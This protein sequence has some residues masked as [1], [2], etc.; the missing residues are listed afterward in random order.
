MDKEE[1]IRIAR[2]IGTFETSILPY[3]DCCTVFTP[4]PPQAPAPPWRRSRRP[5][6]RWTST[7]WCRR[8]VENEHP[9]SGECMT[10]VKPCT[11]E[12]IAVG[13]ELLLGNIANTD[14]ADDLPERCPSWA[15]TSTTT[16][17]WGTTPTR[18]PQAVEHAR[19]TR[20][21]ILI[22][23][24]GLGPTCDDLTKQTVWPP[25]FG[26]K[27]V[28]HPEHERRAHPRTTSPPWAA[29]MT[30]NNLQQ[31]ML[32]EGCT[33]LD[34][35]WGTAPGCAFDAERRPRHHAP[36]PAPG[37][38][39]PCSSTGRCP[40]CQRLSD[41]DHRLPHRPASSAWASQPGGGHA[42]R[43]D[44][45]A[46]TNPTLAPYAKADE[47]DAA[48]HRQGAPREAEAEAMLAPRGAN[49]SRLS[50]AT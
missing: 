16:P 28:F 20:A 21:D 31:A 10:G 37:V 18:L 32:P 11:A 23:T 40:I 39:R 8:A 17:S 47:C 36:R 19:K 1:I 27:L 30:E 3:E 38:P 15:S 45:R 48:R 12:I 43:P 35:D 44:E 6:P 9:N 25:A 4:Q 22:T 49:R 33:V 34:N 13:T 7:R 42:A 2:K 41:G 29:T 14:A 46:C 50:W 5:R 26:Q 24:G